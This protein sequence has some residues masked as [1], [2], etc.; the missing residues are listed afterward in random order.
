MVA[1]RVSFDVVNT[2]DQGEL[3]LILGRV[4]MLEHFLNKVVWP[5]C[6]SMKSMRSVTVEAV[7]FARAKAGQ[8]MK[9]YVVV[10]SVRGG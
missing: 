1:V 4:R 5:W 3:W 6:S 8:E 7:R 9:D 2:K 10:D